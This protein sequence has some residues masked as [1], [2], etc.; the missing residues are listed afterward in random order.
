MNRGAGTGMMVGGAL[1]AALGAI[2]KYAVTATAEGFDVNV[3][4]VILLIV[5]IVLFGVGLVVLVMGSGRH[6]V[7]RQDVQE[8]PAGTSRVEEI[9]E[10]GTL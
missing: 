1:I 10:R 8:T 9:D 3:V 6:T 4:G 2:L 7:V 5:G